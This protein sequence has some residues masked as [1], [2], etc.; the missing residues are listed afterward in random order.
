MPHT[1]TG[2][3]RNPTGAL[4]I[5]RTLGT[6]T[7]L[8]VDPNEIEKLL[9]IAKAQKVDKVRMM[10][11]AEYVEELQARGWKYNP[12]IAVMTYE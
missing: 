2:D 5:D 10:V 9:A 3:E 1:Y 11:P 12:E 6:C 8:F 7:I 4:C